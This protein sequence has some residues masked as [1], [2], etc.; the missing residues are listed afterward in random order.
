MRNRSRIFKTPHLLLLGFVLA[1]DAGSWP[2]RQTQAQERVHSN[3]VPGNQAPLCCSRKPAFSDPAYAPFTGQV[4]VTTDSGYNNFV[5]TVVDLKNS[6]TAPTNV[7]TAPLLYHGAQ[8]TKMTMGTV[9]GVTLDDQGNIYATASSAYNQDFFPSNQSGRIYRVDGVTGAVTVFQTLPFSPPDNMGRQAALGNISF[10]CVHQ[11]FYVSNLDDGKIYTLDTSGVVSSITWDHGAS[12][13]LSQRILDDPSKAFTP[14]GR[15]IWGIQ[16]FAGRLY[17]AVWWEDGSLVNPSHNT[18]IYSVAL[19]TAGNFVTPARLEFSLPDRTSGKD[20]MPVSDITF[21]PAGELSVA[22]HGM[23]NETSPVAHRSRILEYTPITT[24]WSPQPVNKFG[25]NP[26]IP[27]S[28]AGGLDYDFAPGGR[29]WGSG[30]AIHLAFNDFIYGIEGLPRGGGNAAN[31]VLIDGDGNTTSGPK[32]EIGDVEIPCPE[33]NACC[34][35]VRASVVLPSPLNQGSGLFTL[36]P[37]ITASPGAITKVTATIISTALSFP[38][39][40]GLSGAA[41]SYILNPKIAMGLSPSVPVFPYSRDVTWSSNVGVNLS[42]GVP[43]QFDIQFP[44]APGS[45]SCRDE[46]SFCI[47]YT[48]TDVNCRTCDIIQCYG[49]IKRPGGTD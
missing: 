8:W 5:L 4:A 29:L 49:P 44:P 41:M 3:L 17:Y 36:T 21:G 16:A 48:I 26:S 19:D 14:L 18:E 45:L 40:C 13:P 47:K 6:Y 43:F 27:Q 20:S 32:T 46:L 1:V 34:K 33:A 30:D 37:T 31:S 25:F 24:G 42:G 23:G 39:K 2:S 7:N 35:E 12:L 10:D 22:E 38:T 11:K 15:R 28:A 9:F